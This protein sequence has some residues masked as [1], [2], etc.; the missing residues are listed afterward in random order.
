MKRIKYLLLLIPFLFISN[1][2]AVT[3]C[4]TQ[5]HESTLT[6]MPILVYVGNGASHGKEYQFYTM[7]NT[8]TSNG[9]YISGS[10][11]YQSFQKLC[12]VSTGSADS[13]SNYITF[14]ISNYTYLT[15]N[16]YTITFSMTDNSTFDSIQANSAANQNLDLIKIISTSSDPRDKI[17][18]LT[19]SFYVTT[20]YSGTVNFVFYSSS[21]LINAINTIDWVY[22]PYITTTPLSYSSDLNSIKSNTSSI[23]NGLN[24]QQ[25]QLD[26]IQSSQEEQLEEQKKTNDTLTDDDVSDSTNKANEFFSGFTTDTFGLTSIITAPLELIA[27]ITSSTCSPLGLQVPFVENKTINLPCMSSI[28]QQYFGSFLT[29]YQTITFGI[30]AYW[31]CVRIFALVK[32]FKN[33]DTDKIE[34]LDL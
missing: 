9:D 6:E 27:S 15:G 2:K 21:N 8:F 3:G 18:Y 1:V 23:I 20:N 7:D 26:S 33:P 12:A 13:S 24:S 28:Y 5:G 29:I 31:V 32:D 22:T 10:W 11:N 17:Y 4:N 25:S 30:I 16:V 19:V 34:V 14:R